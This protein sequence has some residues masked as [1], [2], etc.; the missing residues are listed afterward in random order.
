VRGLNRNQDLHL[1]VYENMRCGNIQK[2]FFNLLLVPLLFSGAVVL[3]AAC[4]KKDVIIMN[5]T[6]LVTNADTM[7]HSGNTRKYLALGDSYTIGT[8]VTEVD[9]YPVQTVARLKAGG[10]DIAAPEIIAMNGWT[11]ADLI[12]AT[13]DKPA[14][15]TYD[16]VSVLIG[17]NNQYQGRSLEE[18][19]QQFTQLIQRSI[20]LA[21]GKPDHVFVLSIPDYSVTPFASGSNRPAIAAAID[22]FN[23]ANKAIAAAYNVKY[24]NV[25]DESRKAGSDLS[26]VA[27]D[28]L[29]FSGKEY[30]IWTAMLAPMIKAV[31]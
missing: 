21:S 29:H 6:P 27:A 31:L 7:P 2:S 25:T 9:R 4:R 8:S 15:A 5:Y 13:S 28:G 17:V 23:A 10:I 18:Y 1:C 30:A 12:A 3:S 22:A 19:R 26:L 20:Q 14:G 11:T 16:A 24:L